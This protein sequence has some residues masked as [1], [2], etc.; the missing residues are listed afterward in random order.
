MLTIC[1]LIVCSICA[2][3][4]GLFFPKLITVCLL[5]SVCDGN[6]GFG[7]AFSIVV[8]VNFQQC[9]LVV[10]CINAGV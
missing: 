2:R 5:L 6:L 4:F 9:A 10:G 1:I 8:A 7:N 3:N